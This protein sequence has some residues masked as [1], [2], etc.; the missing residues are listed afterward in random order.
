MN[1]AV[2]NRAVRNPFGIAM[3]DVSGSASLQD[4]MQYSSIDFEVERWDLTASSESGVSPVSNH[5]GLVRTDSNDVISVVGSKYGVIQNHEAFAPL[6]YLMREGFIESIDSAGSLD[7][8]AK[9]FMLANLSTQSKIAGDPHSR[10]LLI[11]TTHDGTGATT[12]RGWL[13]RLH[14]TNQMPAIF[15]KKGSIQRIRHTSRAQNYLQ[16]FRHAV[17]ASMESIGIMEDRINLLNDIDTTAWQVEQFIDRMFPKPLAAMDVSKY[18]AADTVN[19]RQRATLAGLIYD[20]P[21]NDNIR[22]K[23]SALFAAAVE[24]SDYYSRGKRSER[25]LRGRDV[26]FKTRALHLAELVSA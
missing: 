21:T 20:A 11:A 2:T 12:A 6:D 7:N 22:G 13:T 24:Y 26:D 8:G 10:K 25:I 17:I 5:V 23:A 15:S 19:E 18:R 4:A 16:D 1:T 3:T 14:C 9:V